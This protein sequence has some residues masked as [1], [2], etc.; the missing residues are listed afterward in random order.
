MDTLYDLLGA[1]PRDDAETLRV[2]FR[3]AVKGAHPDIM[4]GDPDAAL[5]FRQIIRANEILA[6]PEQRAAYDHLLMLAQIEKDP[7]AAHPIAAR[8]HKIASGALAL[9]SASIVTAGGYF[10]FMHMS[11]AIVAP[12]G[13]YA[14]ASS[15]AAGV[16]LMTRLSASIA[17]VSPADTPDPAAVSA[18]IAKAEGAMAKAEAAAASA[19]DATDAA[20]AAEAEN[21]SPPSIA[22]PDPAPAYANFFHTYRVS[23]NANADGNGGNGDPGPAV[24]QLDTKFTASYVNRGVLFFR[25]KKDE[26]GFPELSPVKRAEKPAHPKSLLTATGKTRPEALPKVVPLPQPRTA[27]R[28]YSH[29]APPSPLPTPPQPSYASAAAAA[30]FQ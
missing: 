11:L 14:A 2:A 22:L 20:P 1:L 29:A 7:A 24:A 25:D 12:V 19:P 28:F 8:I 3:R 4:P 23:G 13:S 26:H 18:F 9:A 6:D 16:D 15:P 5:R 17:A 10:V 27:P 30:G 21:T